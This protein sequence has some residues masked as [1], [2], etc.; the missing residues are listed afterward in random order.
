MCS[1]DLGIGSVAKAFDLLEEIGLLGV[2]GIGTLSERTG[3]P[4]PT[5][6]RMVRTLLSCGYVDQVSPRGGYR[7]T[8]KLDRLAVRFYRLPAILEAATGIADDLTLRLLWPAAIAE[9]VGGQMV[10]RYS[11]I[12][13][14][15]YAHAA[16]TVGKRLSL[17]TSAHGK[18]WLAATGS[19][20]DAEAAGAA[21]EMP[22]EASLEYIR[23]RG[24]ATR[25]LGNDPT[26]NS[27]AVPVIAQGR[28]A[29]TI[30]LT[31]FARSLD[32]AAIAALADEL[33]GAA[34]AIGHRLSEATA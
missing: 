13:S 9:R 12:P 31:F 11:T 26:T 23:A 28:V 24:Y 34:S 14:S 19:A 2:A 29:A 18:A 21:R 5:V 15:P 8:S 16:T 1:S 33:C 22:S 30:G 7:L 27:I 20:D 4:K 17:A 6:V 32:Q 3:L 10:V 25:S